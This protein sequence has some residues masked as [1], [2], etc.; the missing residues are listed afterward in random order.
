MR[1]EG[2]EKILH[3]TLE[4]MKERPFVWGTFDCCLFA[5]D[6]VQALTG[7]DYA[8]GYRGT[9]HSEAEAR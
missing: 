1:V 6:I 4:T 3:D 5:A 7:V 8:A 2:W 9:Y